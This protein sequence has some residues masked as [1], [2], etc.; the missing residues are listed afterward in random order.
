MRKP[1][2]RVAWAER[3]AVIRADRDRDTLRDAHGHGDT[4]TH[5]QPDHRRGLADAG[6]DERTS[7]REPF[8]GRRG[9]SA[10][11]RRGRR[12]EPAALRDA[13]RDRLP[14]SAL[15]LPL[16]RRPAPLGLTNLDDP[17]EE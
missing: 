10:A 13:D 15:T 2:W 16:A 7:Q 12:D 4:I 1:E 6:R 14:R 17:G 9:K 3:D 5:A 8:A 11:G